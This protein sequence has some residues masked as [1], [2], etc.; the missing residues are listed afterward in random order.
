MTEGESEEVKATLAKLGRLLGDRMPFNYGFV[1]LV[2]EFGADSEMHYVSNAQREDVVRMM[3]EFIEST[4]GRFG[5]HIGEAGSGS[6][7]EQIARTRQELASFRRLCARAADALEEQCG[8]WKYTEYTTEDP[9]YA[10]ITELR[11]AGK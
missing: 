10:L 6:E 11:E 4:R 9:M 5:E 7:D 3:Y 8:Y 2:F 1:L